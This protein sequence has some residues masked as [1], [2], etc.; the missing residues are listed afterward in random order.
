M[1]KYNINVD[2]GGTFTDGFFVCDSQVRKAKVATT[3]H[4][5]TVCFMACLEE[6]ARKFG[7]DV[8]EMMLRTDVVRYS[9]TVGTNAII[10][11]NGPK[12]GLLVTKGHERDL[13]DPKEENRLRTFLS[14][15]MIVGID[16][17]V[18][19]EG[20][21]SKEVDPSEVVAAAEQL[22]D[23]G[24]KAVVVSFLN[25][26][27]NPANERKVR[28]VMYEEYPRHYLGGVNVLL[29]SDVTPRIGAY[30]RTNT[31]VLNSYIHA[32]LVRYLHKGDEE[33]TR[34]GFPRPMSVVHNTGGMATLAKTRA[35]DTHDSGP[36]AGVMAAFDLG[37]LYGFKHLVGMD[38][39]GTS[40]DISVV[41]EGVYRYSRQANIEGIP[42]NDYKVDVY[43]IGAG[44]GSIAR[45]DDGRLRVGPTSA[46]S[47]PGPAC[48]DL[49][50]TQPTN[51]DASL[52]LGFISSE[53]FA[54]GRKKLACANAEKAIKEMVAG[55]LNV[56]VAEAA[57][58]IHDVVCDNVATAIRQKLSQERLEATAC[59]LLAFGGQ[60]GIHC[61]DVAGR[62][63]MRRVL[64]PRDSEVFSALGC[65]LM[66][67]TSIKECLAR[68]TLRDGSG[69]L[70]SDYET[71]NGMVAELDRKAAGDMAA[72]GVRSK[73]TRRSLVLDFDDGSEIHTVTSPL[74]KV[75]TPEDVRAI[76]AAND[77]QWNQGRKGGHLEIR[78]MRMH[79]TAQMPHY[80]WPELKPA[81]ESPEKAAKEPR[82]VLW[83]DGRKAT[84]VY[85][86]ERLECGAVV[87]G[88]AVIDAEWTTVVVPGGWRY[89]VD[90]HFNGAIERS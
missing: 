20:V 80:R 86:M 27:F 85:Q 55:P 33:L 74:L 1:A 31:A 34:R 8:R 59:T 76:C 23:N 16:E 89:A 4:D 24:A 70:F 73:D 75:N 68:L 13:Y 79:A 65:S 12:L 15:E 44:G 26:E 90:A 54:G 40:T 42:I 30:P 77:R 6:G 69:K 58:R 61:C 36:T 78:L 37:R 50:G 49:G 88:P 32:D 67:T 9:T 17:T 28:S 81:G 18:T 7:V 63:G 87:P 47:L 56:P 46:G 43:G 66:D 3:P 52:V 35:L 64:V 11:R 48:Y 41:T 14:P 25:S 60:G 45:V 82:D 53:G 29:A 39:G 71:F 62:L 72:M 57:R 38:I 10:Q 5:Q 19:A 2:V 84:K 22:L 21:L 51:C 83:E